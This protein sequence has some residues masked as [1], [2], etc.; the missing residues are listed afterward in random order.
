[1]TIE[2]KVFAGR[3]FEP[4]KMLD[5]GFIKTGGAYRYETDFMN[6]DFSATVIIFD[7]G[8]FDCTVVDKMNDEEYRPLRI[9]SFS[10][11]YVNSVRLAY[12]ALLESI[13]GGCCKDVLFASDQ[14]NRIAERISEAF[15]VAPDFPWKQSKYQS[16]GVFRH[17]DNLKWFALIMNVRRRLI[18]KGGD[19]STV[20]IINLK[21]EPDMIEQLTR[22]T[23]IYPAYHMNRKHWIS[24]SLDDAL[25][26][27]GVM[28]LLAKSFELTKK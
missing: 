16:C 13:A 5:F 14:A 10:G 20:D 1:M 6:G 18:T 22:Q 21:S 8:A 15:G 26:D 19:N 24:V 11:G 23:G 17:A 7:N 2:E 28:A 25:T 12:E 3:R 9:D 4:R 27:D